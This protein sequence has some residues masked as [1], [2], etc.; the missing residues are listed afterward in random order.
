M[1]GGIWDNKETFFFRAPVHEF[2]QLEPVISVIQGSVKINMQWLG[3]EIRGQIHR[4]EIVLKT[5]RYIQEI[6]KQTYDEKLGNREVITWD[7]GGVNG[8]K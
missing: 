4:G 5:Q 3:R 8:Y 1:S 6:D 2:D 7:L